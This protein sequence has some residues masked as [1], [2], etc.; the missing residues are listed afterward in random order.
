MQFLWAVFEEQFKDASGFKI[1]RECIKTPDNGLIALDW[2]VDPES[3][4]V[5]P[6]APGGDEKETES[7]P[8]PMAGFED[9]YESKTYYKFIEDKYRTFTFEQGDDTP[10]L[11]IFT[12]YCGDSMSMPVRNMADYFC[13]RGW[14]VICYTK[15]G[16][17]SPY[18]EM[19]PL[20]NHKTFDLAGMDDAHLAVKQVVN[21]YPNAP[22][23]ALGFS[24]GGSQLQD[25]LVTYN[26]LNK[27]FIGGIKVDGIVV[28]TELIKFGKRQNLISKVLGEVVHSS[29]VKSLLSDDDCKSKGDEGTIDPEKVALWRKVAGDDGF[30][31][32]KIASIKS[33]ECEIIHAVKEIMCPAVGMTDAEAYLHSV[34]PDD[35]DRI[36]VPTLVFNSWNDGFQDPM[37]MP[38]GIANIN[39]NISIVLP[40]W[41]HIA[42]EEREY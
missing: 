21:R 2:W 42:F 12:T 13:K 14:R 28:W 4:T 40:D 10:I 3:V 33:A 18:F 35:I 8:E 37:D 23:V 19:L 31:F 30:N 1:Y 6:G 26:R 36:N 34:S 5:T 11:F 29:Y 38:I 15:R 20:N 39:P 17:G 25:F 24:L 7:E 27:Y 41:E 16:C 9:V 22:K 32:D